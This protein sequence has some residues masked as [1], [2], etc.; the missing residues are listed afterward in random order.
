MCKSRLV[1]RFAIT[2]FFLPSFGHPIYM[3]NVP[4]YLLSPTLKQILSSLCFNTSFLRIILLFFLVTNPETKDHRIR[5]YPLLQS[6]ASPTTIIR[7]PPHK[8]SP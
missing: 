3:L 4:M 2:S 5:H 1:V 8:D 7:H 6:G